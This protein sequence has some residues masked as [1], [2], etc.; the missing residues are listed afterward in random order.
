[1][2]VILDTP[3]QENMR[4]FVKNVGQEGYL[5]GGKREENEENK[6]KKG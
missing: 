1:M 2:I 3:P 4:G 5:K 6:C